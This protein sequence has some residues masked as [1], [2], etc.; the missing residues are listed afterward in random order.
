[1]RT[2]ITNVRVFDGHRLLDPATVVVDGERIGTDATG[3]RVV[4]GR[5]GALLP[6]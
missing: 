3:A 5:G 1:M 6:G 4:D 2:A